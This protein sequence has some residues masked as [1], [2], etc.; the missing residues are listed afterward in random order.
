VHSGAHA[1]LLPFN[2]CTRAFVVTQDV[3]RVYDGLN[4]PRVFICL[5]VPREF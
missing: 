3:P 5:D 4:G 1:C 2:A